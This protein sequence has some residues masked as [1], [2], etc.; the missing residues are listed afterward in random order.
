MTCVKSLLIFSGI[1][2]LRCLLIQ[3]TLC[4]HSCLSLS[5]AERAQFGD[6]GMVVSL[7]L[8][9]RPGVYVHYC[10]GS[11]ITKY[12]V[13]TSSACKR[14]D[15]SE[16]LVVSGTHNA[17]ASPLQ[18]FSGRFSSGVKCQIVYPGA[19]KEKV[20]PMILSLT[21]FIPN[22]NMFTSI[23]KFY[24]LPVIP[25]SMILLAGFGGTNEKELTSRY[26][27]IAYARYIP[28]LMDS[29]Y[30]IRT[31]SDIYR[32]SNVCPGDQGGPVFIVIK[33][34]KDNELISAYYQIGILNY[35][36]G[37]CTSTVLDHWSINIRQMASW[38]K[39]KLRQ[40]SMR[41]GCS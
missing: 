3:S 25:S 9:L 35:I 10:G 7:Q 18:F 4:F 5:R 6:I 40:V 12:A 24:A 32:Y 30:V 28:T 33:E 1:D 37:G 31:S 29:S 19:T 14:P 39:N 22:S 21:R 27:H 26:L 34:R 41:K 36:K 17:A 23:M 16:I 2:F 38:I 13:L 11:L 8:K 20:T 15:V